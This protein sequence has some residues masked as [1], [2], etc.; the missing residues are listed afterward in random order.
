MRRKNRTPPIAK[1]K[2]R[3][4]V[5]MILALSLIF[6]SC[7]SYAAEGNIMDSITE[8]SQGECKNDS[9][10][11]K[12]PEDTVG[13]ILPEDQQKRSL[14]TY[15]DATD[16]WKEIR[17]TELAQVQEYSAEE[18]Q[19]I[20]LLYRYRLLE[21]L[22]LDGFTEESTSDLERYQEWHQLFPDQKL[23]RQDLVLESLSSEEPVKS[24]DEY[25]MKLQE[26]A[27]LD[28]SVLDQMLEDPTISEFSSSIESFCKNSVLE[29]KQEVQKNEPQTDENENITSSDHK[30]T[31]TPSKKIDTKSQEPDAEPNV[32]E[33][34]ATNEGK[35]L[36]EQLF[37]ENQSFGKTIDSFYNTG[38]FCEA[39]HILEWNAFQNYC[40]ALPD[41]ELFVFLS[42][43]RQELTKAIK[44]QFEKEIP[45]LQRI[46]NYTGCYDEIYEEFM[47]RPV[48]VFNDSVVLPYLPQGGEY[49]SLGEYY[50]TL[51]ENPAFPADEII[52]N[53]SDFPGS[54]QFLIEIYAR[55][56]QPYDS[57]MNGPIKNWADPNY[58]ADQIQEDMGGIALYAAPSGITWGSIVGSKG[59]IGIYTGVSSTAT[60]T[61]VKLEV[62]FWSKWSVSDSS[63]SY[64][65]N[66]NATTATTKIGSR[67]I[68]HTVASG[69]GWST[70]NQTKLGSSTYTYTRGA[71]NKTVSYAAKFSG[72]EAVGG[73]MTCTKSI[74]VPAATQ[75]YTVSY[76]ANGGTGSMSASTATYNHPFMTKK[77]AFSRVGYTF[78]GWNEKQDGTGTAWTLTSAGVAEAGKT[79]NYT[80]TKNITLYAQWK[81]GNVGV[82]YSANGGIMGPTTAALTL[83]Q[84][85]FVC[86]NGVIITANILYNT[87]I[88]GTGL[89][90][91][92]NPNYCNL[93]KKGFHIQKGQEWVLEKSDG[94]VL[95]FDEADAT[96]KGSDFGKAGET[97]VIKANW[98][99]N[100][101]SVAYHP[102]GGSGSMSSSQYSYGASAPLSENSFIKTGYQFMGW[103]TEE[104]GPVKY[105]DMESI[106]N[107]SDVD[108]SVIDLYA[109]WEANTYT[110]TIN[111]YAHGFK[112][113]EGNNDLKD[114][115]KLSTSTFPAA[116][117]SDYVM[118][119]TRKTNIPNGFYLEPSFATP[120]LS[121]AWQSYPMGT[122]IT[123]KMASMN[124]EYY[125]SPYSYKINYHLAGGVNNPANPSTYNI[126]YG[127]SFKEPTREGY[128][129]AGWEKNLIP[130]T[131]QKTTVE[132]QDSGNKFNAAKM[133]IYQDGKHLTT[134]IYSSLI[135]N[136]SKQYTHTYDTGF[137][138]ILV[139]ANG[140]TKDYLEKINGIYL[141]KGKTYTFGLTLD[142]LTAN[143]C[144]MSSIK[145]MEEV[146]GINEGEN[147]VF[148]SATELYSELEN[149]Q[150]GDVTLYAKWEIKKYT[151]TYKANGGQGQEPSQLITHGTAWTTQGSIFSK[152]GYTLTSWNTKADGSG[153][154]FPL[155]AV[156]NTWDHLTLYAQYELRTTNVPITIELPSADIYKEHG[157][158]VFLV[159]LDGTDLNGVP[160]RQ[161]Q[162]VEFTQPQDSAA[163]I[164]QKQISFDKVPFGTYKISIEDSNRFFVEN[165]IADNVVGKEI[166]INAGETVSKGTFRMKKYEWQG[167]SDCKMM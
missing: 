52:R 110:N 44:D 48:T 28:V 53:L 102:N 45:D 121:D 118:D 29:E 37:A 5:A 57:E 25:K 128:T 94:T 69:S 95:Y 141:E 36:S 79:W 151:V 66:A 78:N 122:T 167:F 127:V 138:D 145:I 129:F 104:N 108:G 119:E 99:P 38:N 55:F 124:Y 111:H 15:L 2:G 42:I 135:G 156:Q 31:D 60:T 41:Q 134:P 12:Q 137:Y 85:G 3:K 9:L 88:G 155:N 18:G 89:A 130:S 73:T 68:K 62:W 47:H 11:D 8:E 153:K 59:R 106:L 33:S 165:V 152:T 30:S 17:K 39:V 131:K 147:A 50:K 133:Q 136:A 46:S 22:S 93:Q 158:P 10:V 26:K 91:V 161:Y 14:E 76:H 126:L 63:N 90:N 140:S 154:S 123:Q 19:T 112:M 83:D 24:L 43:Y 149:R 21:A 132:N 51:Y 16:F 70:S 71:S 150:T 32:P 86:N 56:G 115:Y 34:K 20:L 35:E 143:E 6:P 64:Y 40:Q 166:V 109:V 67:T 142:A 162:P 159:R 96:Y 148:S 75:T 7:I 103:S 120:D 144:I 163:S 81:E 98:I 157:H 114:S 74:T 58:V 27:K 77:N 116:Y 65:Y 54:E 139:G 61:T 117:E 125:Y 113:G 92:Q 101:Y 107:L 4:C 100:Q 13:T 80:Y 97:V 87:A 1:G 23:A 164:I 105:K 49:N 82:R 72:I 84:N 160:H 146:T